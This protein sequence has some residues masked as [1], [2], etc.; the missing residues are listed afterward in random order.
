MH[1]A[2]RILL[3]CPVAAA[4]AGQGLLSA[5]GLVR[6]TSARSLDDYVALVVRVTTHPPSPLLPLSLT[7]LPYPPLSLAPPP[8]P[9]PP[10]SLTHPSPLPPPSARLRVA[11]TRARKYGDAVVRQGP[12]GKA[13]VLVCR[14]RAVTAR[15][16]LGRVAARRPTQRRQRLMSQPQDI[17]A[18][19]AATCLGGCRSRPAVL[20]ARRPLGPAV[21]APIAPLLRAAGSGGGRECE[22]VEYRARRRQWPRTGRGARAR[23]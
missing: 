10:L 13:R 1:P 6:H 19:L 4:V 14:R 22:R 7:P 8:L 5:A 9:Y 20:A 23:R 11:D 17:L 16:L 21:A 15:R 18:G 12:Q 3:T 2:R